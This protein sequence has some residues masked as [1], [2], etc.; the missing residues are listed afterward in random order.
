MIEAVAEGETMVLTLNVRETCADSDEVG[1]G[2]SE[3]VPEPHALAELAGDA[4]P[5]G[6]GK[7][8]RDEVAVE[9]EH[10]VPDDVGEMEKWERP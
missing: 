6:V 9:D 2:E 3:G 4:L 8:E 7:E 10:C 5:V 1:V